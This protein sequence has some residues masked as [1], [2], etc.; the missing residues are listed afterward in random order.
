MKKFNLIA[1]GFAYVLFNNETIAKEDGTPIIADKKGEVSLV[2]AT[3]VEYGGKTHKEGA[4]VKIKMSELMGWVEE[5][6]WEN[7]E[8]VEE[9]EEEAPEVTAYKEKHKELKK[10]VKEVQLAFLDCDDDEKMPSLRKAW[11][12]AVAKLEAHEATA[13]KSARRG[14]K[15]ADEIVY[16]DEQKAAIKVYT[17]ALEVVDAIK[18]KLT[19]AKEAVEKAKEG[20]PGTY[21]VK[22]NSGTSQGEKINDEIRAKIYKMAHIDEP[23]SGP[24]AIGKIFKYSPQYSALIIK[25]E[26][27]KKAYEASIA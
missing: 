8:D 16:N 9:K 2:C 21:K 10:V 4:T 11:K 18:V 25:D 14:R 1:F 17:D 7:V 22:G 12:A 26:K 13:P 6:Q 3:E 20:L 23:K 24:S 5:D 27:S 15:P 19:E